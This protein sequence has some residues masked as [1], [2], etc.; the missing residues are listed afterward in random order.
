MNHAHCEA[1]KDGVH[2]E[3]TLSGY[4]RESCVV[5]VSLICAQRHKM[6]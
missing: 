1:Q 2:W 6:A 3:Y 4:H 5:L